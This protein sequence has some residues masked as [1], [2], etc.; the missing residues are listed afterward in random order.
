[1]FDSVRFWKPDGSAY[2]NNVVIARPGSGKT[3]WLQT[4][5]GDAYASGALGKDQV[6]RTV[7]FGLK[8]E[9]WQIKIPGIKISNPVNSE[10]DMIKALNENDIVIV[11]PGRIDDY[12][13]Y[14]DTMI[15]ALFDLKDQIPTVKVGKQDL[16]LGFNVIVDDYQIA[17]SNRKEPSPT[18]KRLWIAS[19]NQQFKFTAV[20]HRINALPRLAAGNMSEVII[21]NTSS[22]DRDQE[23][24]IL[25]KEL[26]SFDDNLTDY[27]WL[28]MDL[29]DNSDNLYNA[30]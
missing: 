9:P 11:H 21:M 12:S 14:L 7:Y 30:V 17:A 26:S 8:E 16:P 3:Y 13:E 22:I 4:T 28:H 19:R 2:T 29:L 25:G 1:M 23:K 18:M 27:R 5:L 20:M 10:E 6:T 15:N 24:R